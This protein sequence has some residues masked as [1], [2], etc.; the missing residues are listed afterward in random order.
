MNTYHAIE[1]FGEMMSVRERTERV[2][3]V[4]VVRGFSETTLAE[5]QRVIRENPELARAM[6][7][8]VQS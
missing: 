8:E 5:S 7:V 3:R 2:D 1:T 4:P 6:G